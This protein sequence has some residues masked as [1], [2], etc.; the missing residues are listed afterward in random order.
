MKKYFVFMLCV[1]FSGY[2]VSCNNRKQQNG[3]VKK[4]G[5][6]KSND[7]EGGKGLGGDN[8]AGNAESSVDTNTE[9]SAESEHPEAKAEH[10]D[11]VPH[12]PQPEKV[13]DV[14]ATVNQFTFGT[15]GTIQLVGHTGNTFEFYVTNSSNQSKKRLKIFLKPGGTSVGRVGD[16]D[17]VL[18][19]Y[20]SAL[21]IYDTTSNNTDGNWWKYPMD[22]RTI[23]LSTNGN[24][25]V[26]NVKN[27]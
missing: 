1:L 20:K 9:L 16:V 13:A 23:Q 15:R 21:Y 18:A 5:I 10:V 24:K 14:L 25:I 4:I 17:L 7:G 19:C 12:V 11:D 26:V 27:T 8:P 6:D 2:L 22:D 3:A